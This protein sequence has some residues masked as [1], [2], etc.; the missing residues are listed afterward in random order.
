[1]SGTTSRDGTDP[2][3]RR[4]AWLRK[5]MPLTPEVIAHRERIARLGLHTVCQSAR[6]PNLSECFQAGNATFLILGDRCTRGCAF[7]AIG[8]GPPAVVD[9][10]E[11]GRIAGHMEASGIR[12]A[13]ITSVTRDDLPD[14]GAAHFA[15]VV[16][17]IRAALPDAGIELLVP[18]F[19]GNDAAVDLVVGL[20]IQVFAHNLE[21]VPSLYPRARRGAD[22]RRSLA[23]LA[24][25]A[26]RRRPGTRI[27][28]GVMVGLGE[29]REELDGLFAD[30][31]GAG[32]EIITIGQY[33]RPTWENLP[34]ARY[35][36]PAEFAE[37][38]AAAR[39]RGI[40]VAVAGPYV[41]SSYLAE[42]AFAEAGGT[43]GPLSR[44][45][46]IP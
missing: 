5:E 23:V 3:G 44:E 45:V 25:A 38:G 20:P 7:C 6:C 18:D 31:A 29:R 32:V 26:A 19:L 42:R 34:V 46:A 8:H 13:V 11:G 22:Y 37:L 36:P 12:Y 9:P 14:G 15:S 4:P 43:G 33:L 27:K 1:M 2:G 10:G 39:A 17:A 24:R 21:T 40:P 41:R 30:A 16:A 28:T 35:V